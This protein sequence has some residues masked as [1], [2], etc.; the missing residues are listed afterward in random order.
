[1]PPAKPE[2]GRDPE[3]AHRTEKLNVLFALSA[4]GFWLTLS[5]MI[6]DDYNREWKKYQLDF[7]QREAKLTDQQ[8][9]QVRDKIG[10]DRI[11]ALDAKLAQGD[12]EIQAHRDAV[13]KA[14]KEVDK[15]QGEWY[16]VDQDFRFTKANIDVKRYEYEE[17][18]HNNSPSKDKKKKEVEKLEN[19]WGSLRL[20]REAVEERQAAAKARLEQLE[21]TKLEAEKTQK[22]LLGELNRLNE[23]YQSLEQGFVS[24][25][26]NLPVLDLANPS[27]KIN[28][29]M[30]ANLYDD[31]VFTPTPKVDRCTTCHLG[32]DKK[33]FEN[34]PQPYTTHPDMDTYLRGAHPIER[35]GCT[36]CHQGRGRATGFRTA[37]HTPGDKNQERAWGKYT[38]THEFDAMHYWDYP[39]MARGHTEAQCLKCHQGVVEVPKAEHLNTGNLLIEKYGCFGCHKIKGWESLRKVGP[40]LTKIAS[41]TSE[42]WIFRW[43]KE[44]KGFR[45]TRMPQIWDVRINETADQK[46]RN[47]VEASAVAAYILDKSGRETYPEPPR[48]DLA[49]GR[50]TFESVG[51]LACHRIGDDKRGIEGIAAAAFRTHGPN[52]DGTGSKVNAGW[53]YAWVRNPK[54]YW[55]DTRMPDLRLSDKEAADI[56][57]YLMSLKN[58]AFEAR[59]RPAMKA[60]LRDTLVQEYLQALYTVGQAKQKLSA[61]DDR[62]RTL[63]LG[64]KTIGRYGCF[65]CHTISGFENASPVGVE[66]TEEG[67]KVVERLDFG[68]VHEIPNTLPGWVKQKLLEP[69]IF[70]RQKESKKPEEWLRMPKFH[71]TEDEADAIVT[72]VVSLTKDQ[73]PLAAQ[74]QLSADERYVEKGQRLVRNFNCQACHIIGPKGGTIRAVIQDQLE[75]TGQDPIQVPAL[76]PPLLYND[77][78]KSGEGGRV[79]TPWLHSFVKD[80]SNKIRPWL[81]IRMPTFHFTE[82]EVN[83]ITRYFA[84]MDKVPYPYDAPPATDAALVAVGKDLFGRWQCVKCHVVAGKLPNQEPVN[85]APDLA[86]VPKRLRADWIAQWLAD[87]GRIQPGTRMPSDF[88]TDPKENAYPEILGGD[89][90]KQIAAVRAYLLSLS[91][92]GARGN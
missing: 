76:S 65:G 89:P 3:M 62:Q 70:D 85:M 60:A 43:I 7:Q 20:K 71:L 38:H 40:D 34:A 1:M 19:E 58:E 79:Q 72:G 44:P 48:G 17:A 8:R 61:M 68:F 24:K 80:P 78:A 18:L 52:L 64:E 50:K 25:V 27:L 67:S 16:G 84:A 56:T 37:A 15:L 22:E 91:N 74:K 69:R 63:Y 29:I 36:A 73:T 23:K 32:I 88:P 90:S 5:Y 59:P 42:E 14:Q 51:C 6:W 26:R 31:V 75:S 33:G 12:A 13:L 39:M 9:H 57:S 4:I 28:Q 66:L 83:T 45:P 87:P 55:H 86:N 2:P 46:A 82:E 49:A 10:V 92:E 81:Q 11:K 30:P 54:G 77:K 21:K 53:L 41:K 47:D 35:I